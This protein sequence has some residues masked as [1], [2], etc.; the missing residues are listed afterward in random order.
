[1]NAFGSGGGILLKIASGE[2]VVGL[3]PDSVGHGTM[4]LCHGS[5]NRCDT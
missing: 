1:M 4:Q 5:E 2:I 3:F